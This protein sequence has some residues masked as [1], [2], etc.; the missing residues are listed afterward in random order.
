MPNVDI[1][2]MNKDYVIEDIDGYVESVNKFLNFYDEDIVN[3]KRK[4]IEYENDLSIFKKNQQKLLSVIE[5]NRILYEKNNN[6]NSDNPKKEYNI[7][8]TLT[9]LLE[10]NHIVIR[11]PIM[12][13]KLYINVYIE[14]YCGLNKKI[15]ERRDLLGI[16]DLVDKSRKFLLFYTNHAVILENNINKLSGWKEYYSRTKL[17]GLLKKLVETY[18]K[19]DDFITDINKK[20]I[21]DIDCDI[22]PYD[23]KITEHS[24]DRPSPSPEEVKAYRE[25]LSQ[26]TQTKS[27]FGALYKDLDNPIP[28]TTTGNPIPA[29][30]KGGSPKIKKTTKKDV[31]GKERCIYK[32]SGDRKE[33]VKY[34][35]GLITLKDYK[36][37][38]KKKK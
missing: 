35:G 2:V 22:K 30:S 33:Y 38:M 6:D 18:T 5:E 16:G 9:D 19:Y 8:K 20:Y 26:S 24:V 13:L 12:S 10:N 36:N 25:M 15:I 37:I 32:I 3:V 21:H 29:P 7:Y 23:D 28:T 27:A 14:W 4:I 34:K 31:L 11:A 1:L 17:K